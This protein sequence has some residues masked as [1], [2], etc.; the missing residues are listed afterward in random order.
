MTGDP[1]NRPAVD[2]PVIEWAAC[3]RPI[4]GEIESGD[5]HVAVD[6]PDGALVGVIDGLGHGPEAATAARAAAQVL[7]RQASAPLLTLFKACHEALRATRGA[8]MSLASIDA[9]RSALCW[10]GVG[11]V[12]AVLHRSDPRRTPP[13]ERI[14]L[15]GGVVGYQLPPWRIVELPLFAGDVLVFGTD[16]LQNEFCEDLPTGCTPREH[17]AHL[18][19]AYAR[20]SDDAHVLVARYCGPAA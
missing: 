12:E 1:P 8:V 20:T 14:L 3:G 10:A 18:L 2:R 13:K 11:N 7:A 5:L 17:A 6:F 9:A 4:S 16:G 19:E 15:R